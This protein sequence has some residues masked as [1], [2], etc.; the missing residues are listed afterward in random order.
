MVTVP[1]SPPA[2]R[3]PR[4]DQPAT[5]FQTAERRTEDGYTIQCQYCVEGD[6][7]TLIVNKERYL[8]LIRQ[9]G[10]SDEIEPEIQ[11]LLDILFGGDNTLRLFYR[12]T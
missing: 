9:S 2:A 5:Q 12:A 6:E 10:G 4:P 8:D 7:L 11:A 3:A 1:S